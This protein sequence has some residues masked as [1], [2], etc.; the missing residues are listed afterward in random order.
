MFETAPAIKPPTDFQQNDAERERDSEVPIQDII[1]EGIPRI[2]VGFLISA[3]ALSL[4]QCMDH[5]PKDDWGSSLI[6]EPV[7]NRFGQGIEPQHVPLH[8]KLR[9]L[10]PGDI[11]GRTS[12]L[13]IALGLFY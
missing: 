7:L 10:L 11:E 9:I 1:D 12:E 5:L 8:G 4:K 3:Q 6:I 2:M 13:E